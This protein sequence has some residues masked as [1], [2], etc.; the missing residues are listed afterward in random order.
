MQYLPP[1]FASSSSVGVPSEN[2]HGLNDYNDD[3]IKEACRRKSELLL[4]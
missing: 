4:C 1:A 3:Q 2:D